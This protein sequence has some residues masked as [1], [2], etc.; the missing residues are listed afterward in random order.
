MDKESPHQTSGLVSLNPVLLVARKAFPADD[1]K[2]LVAW[3]ATAILTLPRLARAQ[4]YP[5]RPMR[6]IVGFPAGGEAEEK[7]GN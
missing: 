3:S 7:N 6:I 1:L 2:A 4:S 5:A